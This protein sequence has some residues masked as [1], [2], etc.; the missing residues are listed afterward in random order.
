MAISQFYF[1]VGTER[2]RFPLTPNKLNVKRG[3]TSVSFQIIKKGEHKIPRG[4]AA[5]GYSWNGTLPGKNKSNL[6]FI[7]DWQK[8]SEIIKLLKKWQE[9]GTII[10]FTA[11]ETGVKDKVFI[12]NATY[13]Y[14]GAGD[15]DYQINLSAYR[16][17]T[18]TTAPPQPK[19][20]IPKE[21]EK[22][23]PTTTPKPTGKYN[24]PKTDPKN[25]PPKKPLTVTIP[26]SSII[27]PKLNPVVVTTT[28]TR[29]A[30]K[31]VGLNR[32]AM[33]K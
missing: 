32:I 1:T 33:V 15:V 16:P 20:K 5:T 24:P 31:G 29:L 23:K 6:G 7:F 21:K 30:A 9:K 28:P 2:L 26:K 12:D 3:T 17:L 27:K 13:T 19:V 25:K 4:I 18:V 8:P 10:E 11:T 14:T 22:P